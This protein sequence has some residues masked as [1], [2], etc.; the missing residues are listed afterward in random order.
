MK[1]LCT[2][3]Y[4]LGPIEVDPSRGYIRR[5]GEEQYLR[6]K[7]I[8]LLVY[9]LEKRHRLV[10]KE[11]LFDEIWEG[12]AVSDDA[13]VQLIKEVRRSLGDNPRQPQF[14]KTFPKIGY[15]FIGPVEEHLIAGSATVETT[16][17]TTVEVEYEEESA[18][19]SQLV[20]MAA[21]AW[22]APRS[23]R[24]PSRRLILIYL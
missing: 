6:K 13:L 7:G 12:M 3:I 1:A 18:T 5:N 11:E 20:E 22:P 23:S 15:R 4:Q 16:E 24:W 14:I 19:D 8:Q 17:I 21:R 10:T 9:L 2:K